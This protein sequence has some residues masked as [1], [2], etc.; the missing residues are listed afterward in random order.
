MILDAVQSVLISSGRSIGTIIPNVVIE[1]IHRDD[2]IVTDHPVEKGAAISDH[3][4]KRPEEVELR[5]G[6]SNSVAGYEGYVDEVYEELLAL[7]ESRQ[8]FSVS[9]GKRQYDDML[10]SSL[11]VTTDASSE[12]A[13]MV[14]ARCRRVLIVSTQTTASKSADYY[15]QPQKMLGVTQ[16]GLIQPKPISNPVYDF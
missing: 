10:L 2:L 9:T 15:A 6:W 12:Y 13:L 1:E 3:A 5:C 16:R 14:I 11:I 4:F 8:P 7:Q